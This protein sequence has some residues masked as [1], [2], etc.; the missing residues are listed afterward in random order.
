MMIISIV[1]F[2]LATIFDA[3]MDTLK[4][5]FGVSI[6]KNK[7]PEFWNPAVSWNKG[8][9]FFGSWGGPRWMTLDAW[10]IFKTLK[11]ASYAGAIVVAFTTEPVS[12]YYVPALLIGAAFV[13]LIVFELF[14]RF[15]LKSY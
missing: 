14:Y 6:F 7:N 3:I 11:V 1:L 13:R 2:C 9:N 4:D 8:I 12:W 10:H 15:L 5:H